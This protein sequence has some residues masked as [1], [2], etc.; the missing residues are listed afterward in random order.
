MFTWT[1]DKDTALT[2]PATLW[3][4]TGDAKACAEKARGCARYLGTTQSSAERRAG[5][6]PNGMPFISQHADSA[7]KASEHAKDTSGWAGRELRVPTKKQETVASPCALIGGLLDMSCYA[8]SIWKLKLQKVQNFREEQSVINLFWH[9]VLVYGLWPQTNV[10]VIVAVLSSCANAWVRYREVT[11]ERLRS[12]CPMAGQ[13]GFT[14]GV[15]CKQLS[16]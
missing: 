5:T 14:T 4:A 3:P 2:Q 13:K 1:V 6:S 16:A 15:S 12:R 8:S 9:V 7:R 11:C 10:L